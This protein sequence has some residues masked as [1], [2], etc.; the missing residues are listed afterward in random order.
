MTHILFTYYPIFVC[1][2]YMWRIHVFCTRVDVCIHT[3]A[4]MQI[5]LAVIFYHFLLCVLSHTARKLELMV[6][7]G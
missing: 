5:I 6:T 2:V 3:Y 7:A 4:E 1:L